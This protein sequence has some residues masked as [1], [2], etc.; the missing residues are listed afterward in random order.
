MSTL[1][2]FVTDYIHTIG[3]DCEEI[4]PQVYDILFPDDLAAQD[5]KRAALPTLHEL[6]QRGVLRV[7]YDPEAVPEHPGSQLVSFGTPLVN[8]ILTD[9]VHRGR[10]AT[11]Y[12]TGLNLQARDLPT[13]I[14]RTIKLPEDFDWTFEKVRFLH[15]PQAIF[16][17]EATFSSDIKEQEIL[18]VAFDLAT[19]R[20]VRRLD[21]LLDFDRLAQQPAQSLIEAKHAD[22]TDVY[23]KARQEAVRTVSTLSNLR[24][25]ELDTR[26]N[27]QVS[28]MQLYY[29]DL[30]KELSEQE[31]RKMGRPAKETETAEDEHREKFAARLETI[32]REEIQRITELRQKSALK[33]TLRLANL[34]IVQQPKICVRADITDKSGQSILSEPMELVWNPLAEQLEA[35]TCPACGSS[36]FEFQQAAKKLKSEHPLVCRQCK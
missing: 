8:A 2:R 23:L 5:A 35:A 13:K 19:K 4:E 29:S 20:E 27:K 28:R 30:R 24:R 33:V 16:W 34:L 11:A 10:T 21:Q 26:L 15:Y 3:G 9:A 36:T 14:R 18:P 31:S 17:F 25:R 1:Q 32:N 6:A 22:L 7:T 12:I